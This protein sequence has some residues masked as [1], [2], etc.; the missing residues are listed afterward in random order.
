MIPLIKVLWR[1]QKVEEVTWEPEEEMQKNYPE[2]FQGTLSF[3]GKTF[4]R[5]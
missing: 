4:S 1:S 3:E 5:G 2:L